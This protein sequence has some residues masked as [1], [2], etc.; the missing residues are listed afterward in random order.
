MT[1]IAILSVA[2]L[3]V[4]STA[5]QRPDHLVLPLPP[6][7]RVRGA[8]QQRLLA[9]LLKAALVEELPVSDG[10]LAWR[11]DESGQRF[12]LRLTAKGLAALAGEETP[13]VSGAIPTPVDPVPAPAATVPATEDA[14]SD[15]VPPSQPSGKL[16]NVLQ[17]I[18][19]DTG[20]T[21]SELVA[22]TGW[23]PHT[24]RAALTGLRKRGFTVELAEQQGRKAY[25]LTRVA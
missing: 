16:G 2:Q 10:A 3:L 11:Q 7:L 4:L 6:T 13:P 14:A 19:A 18:S 23:L 9:S 5:A 22:L 21:L 12:A 17:A 8:T 25:R 20:A 15:V 1:A 24:T